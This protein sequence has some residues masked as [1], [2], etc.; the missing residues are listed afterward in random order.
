MSSESAI[1]CKSIARDII[2][3]DHERWKQNIKATC[4]PRLL[5][6]FEQNPSLAKLLLSTGNK[7]LVESCKDKDWGTG[8]LLYDSNA[9]TRANWHGQ[10]FLGESLESVRA[11]LRTPI[12]LAHPSTPETMDIASTETN[13]ANKIS[14]N[15]SPN[16]V[17]K[18]ITSICDAYHTNLL[19]SN[20]HYLSF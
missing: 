19:L 4:T 7:T 6:K 15:L 12:S 1:E 3:Y 13:G 8:I 20:Q 16:K 18:L 17:R 2:N 5:A 9:L 11:I 14:P 10:G